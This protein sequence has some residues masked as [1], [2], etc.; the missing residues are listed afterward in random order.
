MTLK[1]VLEPEVMDTSEEARDYDAMDHSE[2]NRIFIAD[3]LAAG[4]L[5]DADQSD[6][7]DLGTGTALIPVE[8]CNQYEAC[9]VMAVDLSASMLDLAYYHLEIDGLTERIQLQQIDAKQ[10]P[11]D[12]GMFHLVMSNS[13]VHHIPE[14][15]TA[16][17]EAVR[18]TADE[19]GLFFR[20]LLR[21]EDDAAVQQLVESYAG[22]ANEHQRQMF[23]DSLRA[24]LNLDEIRDIVCSLGFDPKTVQ[25]T[26]D[27]HWTWVARKS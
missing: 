5:D 7:L 10:L 8:L 25:T 2:V 1:R 20:D 19:G 24:A 26:S 4:L 18:V 23:D 16:L 21:P 6:V 22:E 14:P 15:L 27:R 13:I 3:L 11:F 17:T 12:E 9:R